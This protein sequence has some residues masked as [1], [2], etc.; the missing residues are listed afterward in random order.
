[1]FEYKFKIIYQSGIKNVK[2]EAFTRKIDD[3]FIIAED[4]KLKY[5]YQIIL[6]FFKLKIYN[7]KTD[8][9]TFIHKRIQTINEVDEKYKYFC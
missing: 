5:Q 3:S 1:M 4:N 6:I 9:E 2:I 7:M 8:K